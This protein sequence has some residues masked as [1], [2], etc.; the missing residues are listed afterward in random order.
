MT[1]STYKPHACLGQR[2]RHLGYSRKLSGPLGPREKTLAE[3]D[4]DG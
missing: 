4:I 2:A 3:D 1:L